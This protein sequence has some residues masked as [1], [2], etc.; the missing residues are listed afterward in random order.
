MKVKTSITLSPDVLRAVDRAGGGRSNRSRVIETALREFME[1]RAR[2]ARD[3]RDIEIINRSA[4]ALNREAA[5]VIAYQ[6]EP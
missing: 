1:R 4:E 2:A 6:A 3:R 5:D